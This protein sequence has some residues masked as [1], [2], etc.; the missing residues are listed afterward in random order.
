[1]TWFAVGAAA[2]AVVGSVYSS[3]QAGKSAAKQGSAA[4]KAENEAVI[5]SNTQST[6]RNSY[7]AG[8][9]NL[10]LGLRKK[11]EVQEGYDVSAKA[12]QALGAVN[13]NA[14]AAGTV[15]ASV[16]AIAT[17]VNMKWGEAKA[18]LRENHEQ[19]LTNFN[20]ELEALSVSAE[21]EVQHARHYEYMGPSSGEMWTGAAL[22]GVSSFM[23]TYGMK[24][25]SL[26]LGSSS[27]STASSLS[28]VRG[29]FDTGV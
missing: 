20:N 18:T 4:S 1:M 14:A 5:R 17:D 16:D 27:G 3:Q 15:G 19:D 21:G 2:V 7:K 8:M 26:N 24:R 23:G 6:I 28:N 13:A 10:Q 12:Q 29:G 22:A 11:Q 25:M 9:M